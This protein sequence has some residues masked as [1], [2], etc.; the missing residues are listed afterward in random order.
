MSSRR[1][2]S[3]HSLRARLLAYW[4]LLLVLL[5]VVVAMQRVLTEHW[6]QGSATLGV[7]ALIAAA[8]RLA[9]PPDRVGLLAIRGRMA[10]A[11]CY[12]GFG[13]VVLALALTIA[14]GSLDVS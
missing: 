4:P 6:R 11:L 10:D 12:G 13:V 1:S 8:L 9:L 5:M 3:G 14:Q 7:A 2:V